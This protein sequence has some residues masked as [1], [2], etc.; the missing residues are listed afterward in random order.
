MDKINNVSFTSKVQLAEGLGNKTFNKAC[1]AFE[2]IAKDSSETLYMWEDRGVYKFDL[3]PKKELSTTTQYVG[4]DVFGY[5][6]MEKNYN[7]IA[8]FLKSTLNAVK[9]RYKNNTGEVWIDNVRANIDAT[10]EYLKNKSI[11]DKIK[12]TFDGK[13]VDYDKAGA[14]LHLE[15]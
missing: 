1:K 10:L 12:T 9:A 15:G 5:L 11:G 4:R 2:R 8:D 3:E 13:V 7:E 14:C 6:L